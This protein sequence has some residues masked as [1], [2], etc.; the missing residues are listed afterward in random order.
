M[1]PQAMIGRIARVATVV[2]GIAYPIVV[3]VGLSRLSVRAVSLVLLAMLLLSALARAQGLE[4]T[5]LRSAFVPMLPTALLSVIA[6]ALD[7]QWALLL[8]PVLVNLG[9]LATF[10]TSLRPGA[11]PMVERFARLREPELPEGGVA[12]CRAVTKVWIGFFVVNATIS[13]ALALWAPLPWWTLWCGGLAYACI[14]LVFAIEMAVR[15]WRFGPARG[16][17]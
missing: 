4:R 3:Y 13:A 9:L 7:R 8:V 1:Q 10:A 16:R 2:L 12:Y 15:R 14:G 11:V 17:A 5:R 6:G